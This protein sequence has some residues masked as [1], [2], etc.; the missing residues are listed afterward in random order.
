VNGIAGTCR[1]NKQQAAV[2]TGADTLDTFASI[3]D[4]D[5]IALM[6]VKL[7]SNDFILIKVT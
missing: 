3:D 1:Y 2:F 7:N 5:E 4:D 6:T